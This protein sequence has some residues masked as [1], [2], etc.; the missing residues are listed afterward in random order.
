MTKFYTSEILLTPHTS[1][2]TDLNYLQQSVTTYL[3][4]RL[5]TLAPAAIT[6]YNTE[7]GNFPIEEVRRL[8]SEAAYSAHFSTSR[9]RALV[10]L[11]F[12][13]A[14]TEAQNAALKIIEESPEHTLILLVAT[15]ITKILDTIRSRCIV[16]QAEEATPDQLAHLKQVADQ[17]DTMPWQ[18]PQTYSECIEQAALY[19]DRQAAQQLIQHL[20][21]SADSSPNNRRLLLQAHQDLEAN[22]NVQLVLE[23]YLFSQVATHR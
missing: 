18:P 15:Q 23:H 6:Y 7:L 21:T 2:L 3:N 22:Q 16:V 4:Q 13:R 17:G 8:L 9:E 20:L 10:L 14:S 11:N 19:K 1:T 5:P 12:D